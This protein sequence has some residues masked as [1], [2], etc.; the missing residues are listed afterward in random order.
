M[1]PN[2]IAILVDSCTDVSPEQ[3]K[4]YGMYLVPVNII[5]SDG[6]YRDKVDISLEEI[7]E[8]MKTEIPRTSLPGGDVI[9]E[10]LHQI[11]R[12][13]YEKLLV[14]CLSSALSGTFNIIR[15][16]AEDFEGLDIRVIDTRSVGYGAGAHAVLAAELIRKGY[17]FEKIV[18]AVESSLKESH[19][20]FCLA[21]LDYLARG[22]RIGKVS[23]VL[24]S[25]LKIKPIITCNPE[26][27]YVVAAKVRGR[28]QAISETVQLAV[29]EAKRHI[30]CSI[31][32]VSGNAREEAARVMAQLKK[33]VPNSIA[34]VEGDVGPALAVHT[35]PGL[36]GIFVQAIPAME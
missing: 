24:G 32:V 20:Y 23:A 31:A 4:G 19:I 2:K 5:F 28:T 35:G 17:S 10:T 15:I 34:F 12:D 27:A 11:R 36:L 33:L 21:T 8:R 7:Y 18:A 13:G 6:E 3:M 14:V 29:A 22:G 30:T 16:M 26:G 9:L 1:N 25:L